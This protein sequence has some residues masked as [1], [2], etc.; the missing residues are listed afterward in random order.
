M[1]NDTLSLTSALDGVCGQRHASAAYPGKDPVPVV[2]EAGWTP[3]PAWTGTENLATSG[4]RSPNRPA[5][6]KCNFYSMYVIYKCDLGPHN[7]T[8]RDA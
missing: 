4:I 8:W 5:R 6:R 1:Q 7:R 3:A 2:Q